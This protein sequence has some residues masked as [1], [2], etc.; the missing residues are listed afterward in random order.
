MAPHMAFSS[1]AYTSDVQVEEETL[2]WHHAVC[3]ASKE[4]Q[5]LWRARSPWTIGD[6]AKLGQDASGCMLLVEGPNCSAYGR[7]GVLED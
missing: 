4:R 7:A 2:V 6:R 3:F 1:P 5:A